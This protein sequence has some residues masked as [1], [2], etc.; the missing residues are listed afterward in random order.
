VVLGGGVSGLGLVGDGAGVEVVAVLGVGLLV[1]VMSDG[2]GALGVVRAAGGVAGVL[3]LAAVLSASG[4]GV[5]LG[6]G[7]DSVSEVAGVESVSRGRSAMGVAGGVA[8]VSGAL[9]AVG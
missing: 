4:A 7:G 5:L 2:G 3:A 8:S 1:V 9:G 6:P